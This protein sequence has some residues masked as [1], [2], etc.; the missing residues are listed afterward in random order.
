MQ[1]SSAVTAAIPWYSDADHYW[2]M[3]AID[4]GDLVNDETGKWNVRVTGEMQREYVLFDR[5]S[6]L[7]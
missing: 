2:P 5:I 1:F 4:G 6:E 7:L 3:S